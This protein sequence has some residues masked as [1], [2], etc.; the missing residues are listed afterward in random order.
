MPLGYATFFYLN[1]NTVS[2]LDFMN[3]RSL[4]RRGEVGDRQ[5]GNLRALVGELEKYGKEGIP[6]QPLGRMAISE[7]R[8]APRV[9][10]AFGEVGADR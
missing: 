9:A 6:H 4:V 10:E 8:D 7:L 2:G 3:V 5:L 1:S